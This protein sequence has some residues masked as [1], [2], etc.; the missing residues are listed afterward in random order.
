MTGFNVGSSRGQQLIGFFTEELEH[1][2][3]RLFYTRV[4]AMMG[5]YKSVF[6]DR[7]DC[8]EII[9]TPADGRPASPTLFMVYREGRFAL[10]SDPSVSAQL[11]ADW[12]ELHEM[13]Q[14]VLDA[15]RS[16]E[17]LALNIKTRQQIVECQDKLAELALEISRL[18]DS[19]QYKAATRLFYTELVNV[20]VTFNAIIDSYNQLALQPH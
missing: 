4:D 2:S 10:D 16:A 13:V 9:G 14:D 19:D 17:M 8:A 5:F 20:D 15:E 11:D 1:R 3:E 12:L 7:P 18:I 6:D